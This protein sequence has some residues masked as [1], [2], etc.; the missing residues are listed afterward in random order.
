M[1]LSRLRVRFLSISHL[2]DERNLVFALIGVGRE[3]VAAFHG[4]SFGR[5]FLLHLRT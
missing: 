3:Q 2:G 4:L 1:I 5:F